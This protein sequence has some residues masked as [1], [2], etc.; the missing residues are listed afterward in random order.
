MHAERRPLL[1]GQPCCS[2][3][4]LDWQGREVKGIGQP[5]RIHTLQ[6]LSTQARLNMSNEIDQSDGGQAELARFSK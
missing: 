2:S 3:L 4:C 1:N 6:C 5:A